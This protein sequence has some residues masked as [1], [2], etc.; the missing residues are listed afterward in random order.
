MSDEVEL[1]SGP[2]IKMDELQKQFRLQFEECI[3]KMK[4]LDII[5]P[6][7]SS[8]TIELCSQSK[9][10]T[11]TS[12]CV[13]N[14]ISEIRRQSSKTLSSILPL[15][16]LRTNLSNS[17]GIVLQFKR[18]KELC[19]SFEIAFLSNDY[20]KIAK[21][22]LEIAQ[23]HILLTQVPSFTNSHKSQTTSKHLPIQMKDKAPSE[24]LTN[25]LFRLDGK[26][27]AKV[28]DAVTAYMNFI[29]YQLS[30]TSVSS[31]PVLTELRD[32]TQLYLLLGRGDIIIRVIGAC[33]NNGI[34][35]MW[36]SEIGK[37]ER[38]W[39][40]K[41][42]KEEEKEVNYKDTSVFSREKLMITLNEDS[43]RGGTDQIGTQTNNLI[44][45][46]RLRNRHSQK[47][48]DASAMHKEGQKFSPVSC[49]LVSIC[50]HRASPLSADLP[51]PASSSVS[52]CLPQCPSNF[53][54]CLTSCFDSLK[55]TLEYLNS[56][57]ATLL[58]PQLSQLITPMPSSSTSLS[59]SSDFH[60]ST[61]GT[62][63]LCLPLRCL[64]VILSSLTP[65]PSQLLLDVTASAY[66]SALTPAFSLP[67]ALFQRIVNLL[68]TASSSSASSLSPSSS[69]L[70]SRLYS[71]SS[72]A[73]NIQII[74]SFIPFASALSSSPSSVDSSQMTLSRDILLCPVQL[75]HLALHLL[76]DYSLS[77]SSAFESSSSSSSSTSSSLT[78]SS[79]SSSSSLSSG[80][81]L[82]RTSSDDH[83][84]ASPF[85]TAAF[86][87][88]PSSS[89]TFDAPTSSANSDSHELQSKQP[90]EKQQTIQKAIVLLY[91]VLHSLYPLI[92]LPAL[93][94]Q[95]LLSSL[96]SSLPTGAFFVNVVAPS[97]L[98]S[99]ADTFM[100]LIFSSLAQSEKLYK[101]VDSAIKACLTTKSDS[102]QRPISSASAS[103]LITFSPT[104]EDDASSSSSPFSK[105]D[106]RNQN[107]AEC[108]DS[109]E[110]IAVPPDFV[111]EIVQS[112]EA[113]EGLKKIVLKQ[114]CSPSSAMNEKEIES[115]LSSPASSAMHMESA[116]SSI[117]PST[118]SLSPSL[119][120]LLYHFSQ[121]DRVIA[122]HFLPILFSSLVAFA[123]SLGF[124]LSTS[125]SDSSLLSEPLSQQRQASNHKPRWIAA[126]PASAA[127]PAT[128]GKNGI[129]LSIEMA[130]CLFRVYHQINLFEKQMWKWLVEWKEKDGMPISCNEKMS[131]T[132]PISQTLSS[133]SS[134]TPSLTDSNGNNFH[135]NK[136]QCVSLA[137]LS[138]FSLSPPTQANH[139]A[140]F[141]HLFSFT[142]SFYSSQSINSSN[143][144][145]S[146]LSLPFS[147]SS[148][149]QS[150]SQ[151][152]STSPLTQQLSSTIRSLPLTEDNQ[153]D[154]SFSFSMFT[155]HLM[156]LSPSLSSYSLGSSSSSLPENVVKTLSLLPHAHDP[157]ESPVVLHDSFG[158]SVDLLPSLSFSLVVQCCT[159]QISQYLASPQLISSWCGREKERE[160]EL[161]EALS[162]KE[163]TK[164]R[165][166]EMKEEIARIRMKKE[167]E[168][169]EYNDEDDNYDRIKTSPESLSI[170]SVF[171]SFECT[172]SFI[173]IS[174]SSSNPLSASSLSS[175]NTT[176][177]SSSSTRITF[178]SR[179]FSLIA[180]HL[181]YLPT[182]LGEYLKSDEN[183]IQSP[184]NFQ[185]LEKEQEGISKDQI[186][187]ANEKGSKG[188]TDNVVQKDVIESDITKLLE[189]LSDDKT[190]MTPDQ[191]T[192]VVNYFAA[193]GIQLHPALSSLHKTS[194]FSLEQ[195]QIIQAVCCEC[196]DI[197]IS[198]ARKHIEETLLDNLYV[199]EVVERVDF[200]SRRE[201]LS[202]T[203]EK[204]I[205]IANEK[206][207]ESD[208]NNEEAR[209]GHKEKSFYEYS[210]G[211][212]EKTEEESNSTWRDRFDV[213]I[214]PLRSLLHNRMQANRWTS[215]LL[216]QDPICD[217]KRKIE[218][219]K[220]E[221]AYFSMRDAFE[222]ENEERIRNEGL[223][224]LNE[225]DTSSTLLVLSEAERLLDSLSDI[226]VHQ[227]ISSSSL[228]PLPLFNVIHH[229][230]PDAEETKLSNASIATEAGLSQLQFDLSFLRQILATLLP[231]SSTATYLMKLSSSIYFIQSLSK[232]LKGSWTVSASFA[233]REQE[234]IEELLVQNLQK[235]EGSYVSSQ[236]YNLDKF[237]IS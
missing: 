124:A 64:L 25:F 182:Q 16:Q 228:L 9:N 28:N 15:Y 106:W 187:D 66:S 23:T 99:F 96:R 157:C 98:P 230:S 85:S 181:Y 200:K 170:Q 36:K 186:S 127:S 220:K 195:S 209:E 184:D 108:D 79:S 21:C 8:R 6:E 121:Y 41:K 211:S 91:F 172:P 158:Y 70:Q 1:Q 129:Q 148:S 89:P 133:P 101:A 61:N 161:G 54:L 141:D 126:E 212:K 83:H 27:K 94:Q 215:G 110:A 65:S 111:S 217:S 185:S 138:M 93:H 226:I 232:W 53:L 44:R 192:D 188:L 10:L 194:H 206:R 30:K 77:L 67:S 113:D 112:A 13:R 223:E 19:Q 62:M 201:D 154:T 118:S 24:K 132:C 119:S 3:Q 175:S 107:S 213:I 234:S 137:P 235:V 136:I 84:I 100:S 87:P 202:E 31:K 204:T 167:A 189:E 122:Y 92:A 221:D 59:A 97:M 227:Q 219:N 35:G 160:T 43:Q 58:P 153:I 236:S 191:R 22:L 104:A 14:E 180:E 131:N 193:S 125:A 173:G 60:C 151:S 149:A 150:T 45:M 39:I 174:S 199:A 143:F 144:S 134:S 74:S 81:A 164:R 55:P 224:Q 78:S 169:E 156:L 165:I 142:S 29:Q 75:L 140:S 196:A 210:N 68:T 11:S 152:A 237:V 51:L 86:L 146:T 198:M 116:S 197:V 109:D 12:E 90:G 216:Q 225:K 71:A 117:S 229:A 114:L 123:K 2:S 139:S 76:L 18:W 205:E 17:V 52:F 159:Q 80:D 56:L 102:T 69:S 82:H 34:L 233:E 231:S 50:G 208:V 177:S 73:D 63:P 26:M 155:N 40:L 47:E 203:K 145:Q 4:E 135:F 88:S 32:L 222:D 207:E 218:T 103:S 42:E 7:I 130:Q 214:H 183:D 147:V 120:F 179:A 190:E 105:F 95:Y 115:S 162:R 171:S 168:E 178:P 5:Q 46:T 20:T 176:Q 37:S 128:S 57:F 72:T 163:S 48:N 38:R 166:R 49:T 33:A